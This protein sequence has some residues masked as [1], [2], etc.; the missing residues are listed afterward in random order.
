MSPTAFPLVPTRQEFVSLVGPSG[1]GKSTLLRII[2][3]LENPTSGEIAI[4]DETVTDVRAADRNLSMVFQSYALYPHLTVAENIAVPLRMR[5]LSVSQRL[6]VIGSFMPGARG[7]RA[8]IS[9]AVE[10]A[11]NMLE[12]STLLGR[13]P[14]QLSGPTRSRISTH[15]T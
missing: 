10:N 13:K 11:A 8:E 2:A 5:S 14:G 4:G 3:G 6:P 12:I 15:R 1:C 9:S 7:K